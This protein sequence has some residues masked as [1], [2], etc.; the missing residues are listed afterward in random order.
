MDRKQQGNT[1]E[2][3]AI[4]Y[5][6][7]H[8]YSVSKPLFENSNFDLIVEKSGCVK[9]VQVKSSSLVRTTSYEVELRTKGGNTSWNGV[10]KTISDTTVDVVFI[11]TDNGAFYEFD[12]TKLSD[13]R[14][15]R[16]NPAIPEYRGTVSI[17]RL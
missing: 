8:G 2:A 7:L 10:V 16:V 4:Y 6:T 5:Y 12:A 17:K 13:R 3:F 1:A 11:Y 14:S 9:R 15:V